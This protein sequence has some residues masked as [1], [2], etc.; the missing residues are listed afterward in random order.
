MLNKNKSE[1]VG[2]KLIDLEKFIEQLFE[3]CKN[4]H[5]VELL[6]RQLSNGNLS[7][8]DAKLINN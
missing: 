7:P 6:Q 3:K 4:E 5:E 1:K 8:R 2:L